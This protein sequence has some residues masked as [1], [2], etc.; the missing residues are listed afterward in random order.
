MQPGRP[1]DDVDSHQ[2]PTCFGTLEKVLQVSL[3]DA[4]ETADAVVFE[5]TALE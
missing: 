5:L 2:L 3:V 1:V 4:D